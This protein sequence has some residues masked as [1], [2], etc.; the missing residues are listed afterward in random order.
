MTKA[1]LAKKR[2]SYIKRQKAAK[3]LSFA[4]TCSFIAGILNFITCYKVCETDGPLNQY[5]FY[6]C[7]TVFLFALT[8]WIEYYVNTYLNKNGDLEFKCIFAWQFEY[9]DT[10][11]KTWLRKYHLSDTPKN[12]GTY[13]IKKGLI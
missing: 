12:F 5:L 11:Y 3:I 10:S 4:R 8:A 7:S 2:R 1:T 13:L 9:E 6:L